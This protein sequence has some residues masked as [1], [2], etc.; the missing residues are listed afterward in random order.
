MRLGFMLAIRS[1]A[2]GS[3]KP[4]RVKLRLG[5]ERCFMRSS[6]FDPGMV[7]PAMSISFCRLFLIRLGMD[8]VIYL[9]LV[10]FEPH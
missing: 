9:N 5:T 4:V 8:A 7:V 1:A 10:N 6:N 2:E 3:L